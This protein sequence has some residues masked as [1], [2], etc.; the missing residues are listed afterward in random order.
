MASINIVCIGK[1]KEK[2]WKEAQAEYVKRLGAFC[3]INIEEKK[4]AALPKNASAAQ[5]DKA[6]KS[7]S[8]E[9]NTAS[10]G[11][12]IALSPE[13]ERMTS[14]QFAQLIKKRAQI[15]DMSFLIG[16]SHGLSNAIKAKADKVLSFSDMTMPHQLFRVV[17]LEQV[18]R[19]FMIG[20][21]RVYHK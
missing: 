10:R 4:E 20:A 21:G 19:A 1:L 5:I 11:Y 18:Y 6:A 14:Q 13:G 3:R 17:L 7:E 16:G 2:Y 15:G 12:M 9:L 8:E